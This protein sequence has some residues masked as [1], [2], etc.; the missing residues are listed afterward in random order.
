MSAVLPVQ[1][2][3]DT[4]YLTAMFR[5]IETDRSDALFQDAYA[6]MLSE[7]REREILAS[8]PE[9]AAMA[10][11]CIVRTCVLDGLILECV[12]KYGIDTVVNLGSGLDTRAYRLSLTSSLHWIDVDLPAVVAFKSQALSNISAACDLENVPLDVM[13]VADRRRLFEKIDVQADTVLVLTEGLLVYLHPEQVASLATD[14]FEQPSIQYWLSDIASPAALD[15][16]D[17]G[18]KRSTE[19]PDHVHLRFAPPDRR[20]FFRNHGWRTLAFR[21]SIEEGRRLK[22]HVI[23]EEYFSSLLDWERDV[24][25]NLSGVILLDRID[26]YQVPI[27]RTDHDCVTHGPQSA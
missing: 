23:P 5:A 16:L 18:R 1:D 17:A 3:S 4:A 22:R 19:K 24:L 27:C 7:N 10:P 11:G 15:V 12:E 21:S 25:S 13:N 6:R 9:K 26:N 8:L 14:L 20:E 2:I